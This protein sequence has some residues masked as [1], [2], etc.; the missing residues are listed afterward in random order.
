VTYL[1]GREALRLY[2][3][4]GVHL[5]LQG[6][7]ESF[8]LPEVMQLIAAGDRNGRLFIASEDDARVINFA[9]G[10]V[11]AVTGLA[12]R[13]KLVHALLQKGLVDPM[14]L[15]ERMPAGA[16]DDDASM[17]RMLLERSIVDGDQLDIALREQ[18]QEALDDVFHWKVGGFLFRDSVQ[19]APAGRRGFA[20]QPLL[21]EALRKQDEWEELT[22]TFSNADA[23]PVFVDDAEGVASLPPGSSDAFA[24]LELVDGRS[25]V[26]LI[27]RR[28]GFSDYRALRGLAL[29]KHVG[30]IRVGGT[31]STSR[32]AFAPT[33]GRSRYVPVMPRTGARALA[34]AI[35]EDPDPRELHELALSDPGIAAALLQTAQARRGASDGRTS[36][37]GDALEAVGRE[38]A[39]EVMVV[40]GLRGQYAAP[41]AAWPELWKHSL[42]V[43]EAANL[44]GRL[45]KLDEPDLERLRLAGLLH[46]VGCYVLRRTHPT[47]Y[48]QAL[49]EVERSGTELCGVEQR[50][51]GN[52][53]E[54]VGARALEAWGLEV[55]L[56]QAV[57]KHHCPGS[58]DGELTRA[59]Q[60]AEALAQ[61][62]LPHHEGGP[63]PNLTGMVQRLFGMPGAA[64][65][66]LEKSFV[67][68]CAGRA[69]LW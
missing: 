14:H 29:L 63:Q 53:H 9:E 66:A 4:G 10:R 56:C 51:L 46:D 8:P 47:R 19:P 41:A 18:V 69:P 58:D 64:A 60:L 48:R 67:R 17:A 44:V 6:A 13:F 50:R 28:S 5:G 30:L 37:V 26:G 22:S 40:A 45:L 12:R 61:G 57:R 42:A 36:S 31:G 15:A 3:G 65:R 33:A 7:F 16:T 68:T 49:D 2:F 38:A 11:T 52:S 54:H 1:D 24:M 25:S 27:C 35:H 21:M 55:E 23:V 32:S 59:L 34:M 20:V 62:H 39:I 43:S